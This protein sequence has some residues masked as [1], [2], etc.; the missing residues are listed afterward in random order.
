MRLHTSLTPGEVY[1]ALARAQIKKL[2]AA[3]IEFTSG[4][5]HHGS[6]VPHGSRTH[7]HAYEVQLGTYEKHSLPRDYRDRNGQRMNVRRYKNSGSGGASSEWVRGEAVWAATWHE[8]GWFIAEVFAADPT[9]RWGS[10]KHP[11]YASPG[12][13]HHKTGGR[14]QSSGEL[15]S[16]SYRDDYDNWQTCEKSPGHGGSHGKEAA[17]G[18]P[19][20]PG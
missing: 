20:I 9:A 3:D 14:F 2:V 10:Q 5:T 18:E 19:G 6:L 13:F 12:D 7:A 1:Q 4:V 11:N 16:A 17:S 8:W 15:C